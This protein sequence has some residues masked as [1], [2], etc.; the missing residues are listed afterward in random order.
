MSCRDI[1][2][3]KM[4][5]VDNWSK[6]N[7]AA[8]YVGDIKGPRQSAWTVAGDFAF[9]A[10]WETRATVWVTDL[11]TGKLVGTMVPDAS[12]GGVGRTGWVDISS[13]IQ[14]YKRTTTGEYLVFVEDDGLS[15]V[16]LYRWCTTGDCM[17]SDMKVNLTSPEKDKVYFNY[18]PLN[19]AADLTKDTSVV[20]KVEFQINDTIVGQSLNTPYQFTWNQP[21]IGFKKAYAKAT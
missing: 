6:G 15:R 5:I 17:E 20:S 1:T 10:G 12:C 2:G 14:A 16:I 21:T 4:Y 9:E 11:N 3:G 7:R 19:L 18:N 8:R 13:G